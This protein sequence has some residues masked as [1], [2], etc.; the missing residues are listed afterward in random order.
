[1]K[2]SILLISCVTTL[3]FVVGRISAKKQVKPLYVGIYFFFI[4]AVSTWI[5]TSSLF[6]SN[7]YDIER[8]YEPPPFLYERSVNAQGRRYILSQID[9][10]ENEGKK[11]YYEAQ[12]LCW[13]IPDLTQ[14]ETSLFCFST[15]AGAAVPGLPMSRIVAATIVALTNY[16]VHCVSC[17]HDINEHLKQA[18]YHF[19]MAEWHGEAL[20]N[21]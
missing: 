8:S 1:M 4:W 7:M 12:R 19:E 5:M 3:C 16:G 11:H 15:V 9:F 10:H 18:Q 13:Y 6:A 17:W 14:K 20:I 2:Y 21:G